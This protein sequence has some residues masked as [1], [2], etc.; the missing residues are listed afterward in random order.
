LQLLAAAS[1]QPRLPSPIETLTLHFFEVEMDDRKAAL[2]FC[3]GPKTSLMLTQ[4]QREAALRIGVVRPS[5]IFL[6][7]KSS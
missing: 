4:L 1:L 7:A 2:S 5:H 3:D 6:I